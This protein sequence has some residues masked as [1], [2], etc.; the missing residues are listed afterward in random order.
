[1]VMM[2]EPRVVRTH[3]TADTDRSLALRRFEFELHSKQA[4]FSIRGVATGTGLELHSTSLGDRT[5]RLPVTTP[6]VLS[7]TLQDFLG[8]EHIETGK[9][10]RYSLFDPVSGE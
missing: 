8:Q 6:I 1:L 4:D 5:I 9:K 2:G 3:V 10:L 7:E